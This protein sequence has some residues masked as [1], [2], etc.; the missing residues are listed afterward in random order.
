MQVFGT[1]LEKCV[2]ICLKLFF[3]TI[4]IFSGEMRRIVKLLKSSTNNYS[5]FDAF[6]RNSFKHF[7][8]FLE[9]CVDSI[10]D[11]FLRNSFNISLFFSGEMRRLVKLLK[12]SKYNYSIFDAFLRN[13]LHFF[14][15]ALTI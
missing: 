12:T 4:L 11:A 14:Q 10:F 15:R 6:L 8:F 1:F 3:N 5:I 2:D 13:F 7:P 9:K